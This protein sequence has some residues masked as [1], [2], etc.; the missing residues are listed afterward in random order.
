MW[1][2]NMAWLFL[3]AFFLLLWMRFWGQIQLA[4]QVALP[5]CFTR[6]TVAEA[7]EIVTRTRSR[8]CRG[9]DCCEAEMANPAT[10][11]KWSWLLAVFQNSLVWDEKLLFIWAGVVGF[12]WWF[13]F[14]TFSQLVLVRVV[15]L[16][17]LLLFPCIFLAVLAVY[18]L[19]QRVLKTLLDMLL[20]FFSL[21]L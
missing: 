4:M 15:A 19:L 14:S 21:F 16:V 5:C 10:W 18:L 13:S 9:E 6:V 1:L 17:G 8:S 7:C 11:Q 3:R 2:I 12:S 20:L